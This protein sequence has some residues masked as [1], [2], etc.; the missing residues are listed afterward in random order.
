[1]GAPSNVDW[2]NAAVPLVFQ[3]RQRF[4]SGPRTFTLGSALSGAPPH[5][6]TSAWNQLVYG[7]KRWFLWAPHHT[8]LSNKPALVWYK[9]EF[10]KLMARGRNDPMSIPLQ[11]NQYPNDIMFLPSGWGHSTLCLGDCLGY[12]SEVTIVAEDTSRTIGP[13][14]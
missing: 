11:C 5:L 14:P 10:P 3:N 8:F 2:G 13:H 9:R 1:M 7:K 6:H 4:K 12:S